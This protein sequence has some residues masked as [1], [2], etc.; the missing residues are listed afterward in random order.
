MPIKLRAFLDFA[1]P[2]LKEELAG[3]PPALKQ[4]EGR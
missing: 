3:T 2:R 4:G 1:L